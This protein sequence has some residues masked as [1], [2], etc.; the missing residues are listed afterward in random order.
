MIRDAC[1]IISQITGNTGHCDSI[2]RC[3]RPIYPNSFVYKNTPSKRS[4]TFVPVVVLFRE[5][6]HECL[7][8]PPLFPPPPDHLL[9]HLI[10]STKNNIE[11]RCRPN[12]TQTVARAKRYLE[13]TRNLL[14][15]INCSVMPRTRR[16]E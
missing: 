8:P 4:H 3:T 6:Q 16:F 1:I 7:P 9:G 5:E 12:S 10:P 13:H 14:H 11:N 2:L 15:R